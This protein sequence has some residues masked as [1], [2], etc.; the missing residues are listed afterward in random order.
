[1]N[2]PD[3]EFRRE[4]IKQSGGLTLG[5]SLSSFAP[6]SGLIGEALAKSAAPSYSGWEDIYRRMW[7]WDKVTWGSHTNQC[8]PTGCKFYVY[9]RNGIVW[10]EEQTAHT[11]A[12]NSDYVDYNPLGCQK[13]SAFHNTLYGEER[14]KYPLK[15]VGK[16]GEGKWKRVSWDEATTEIAD[17]I[18]D[19][20]QSQ[21]PDGFVLDAPH[22]HAGAPAY[23]GGFRMTRVMGGVFIDTTGDIGDTYL[24]IR[25]TFGKQM[26]GYSADNLLDAE[27]IILTC[28]NWS[29]TWPNGYHW[30]TEARYRGTEVVVI[31][32]D[33]SP[34]AP[35][36]DIHVPVGVGLDAAFWLGVSHVIVEEKLYQAD[37]MR[38]QTDLPVLV[39]M[40]SGRFLTEADMEGADK[41]ANQFYHH[42]TATGALKKASRGTL[43]LDCVPALEGTFTVT[44][45]DGKQV[46]VQP[47]FERLKT[48]LKDY[49]PEQAS[50]KSNVPVSIIRELARKIA[51][52]RTCTY[53][54]FSSAKN[55]HG[56]LMERSLLLTMALT[57]NWGKP[58]TGFCFWAFP[59]DHFI[60]LAL[61]DKTVAEGGLVDMAKAS[62]AFAA[63]VREDDPDATDEVCN[64]LEESA[65]SEEIGIVPP[66]FWLYNH[67]GYDKLYNNLSWSDGDFKGTFGDRLKEAVD[68]GWWNKSHMRPAPG[69][70]PQVLMLLSN[71]PLRRK[72]SGAK[73]YPEVLFPKLEMIFA[74]E[75]RMSSS[76]MFAD[77]VLPCSWYYEKHDMTMAMVGNPFYTYIDRAVEPPG[78]CK[79]EWAAIAMILKKVSER[80][81][82]RGMTTFVD[83]AG[84]TQRY[85]DLYDRYTMRGQLLT[86]EDCLKEMAKVNEATGVFPKGYT[87][88]QF[89]KEGQVKIHG[90]GAGISA[91]AAGNEFS[92]KK[93]FFPLRWHVD[94]KKV[95]PTQTRRAQFYFDHEWYMEAGEALPVFKTPP[96]IGGTHPFAITGGHPRV[97]IH[98]AHLANAHLSRLHRGQPVVHI[99]D[100]VAT[101][102]GLNDGDMA[103]LYND[104]AECEIM[105][106]TAP[107]VQPSELIVYFWEAYQYKGWKPYDIFL[108][109][110]PKALLLARGY[111]Q[112]CFFYNNGSPP[113]AT[114]R[115]VRVSIRKA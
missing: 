31:A 53:M 7:T 108:I 102:Y 72:R 54:G 112:F 100:V 19:S 51:K 47:V 55:Y 104:F 90:L 29:Y 75:V 4:F 18:L 74:L 17:A 16:R 1:M 97:S 45:H 28:S 20:Y 35:A 103:V 11:D 85:E 22:T 6:G 79:E 81:K 80:A 9:T 78:E 8:W 66:A 30:V 84:R 37:F 68:K 3:N 92:P 77:I 64:I 59:E 58:G 87:Y 14:L 114:D 88:E 60:Y 50:K 73:L 57:G 12:S 71:N 83:P 98:S 43:K 86:N 21:G 15:R 27:L 65:I 2:S 52:L 70:K 91:Y 109:G 89:K 105:V 101:Q 39:R 99:N 41:R 13:G 107:N 93:P 40:D 5:L 32:P 113:P 46:T 48:H 56:D 82:K 62:Q 34:T 76:A 95:F 111:E 110:L 33:F 25:H 10:R 106:R 69:K 38:E 23:A 42:D 24:G 26:L 67:C 44:L 61:S 115:G 63:K 94:D 49:T 36:C 96:N